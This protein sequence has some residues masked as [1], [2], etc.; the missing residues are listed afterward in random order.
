MKTRIIILSLI[1]FASASN[2]QILNAQILVALEHGNNERAV[3]KIIDGFTLS[4][5]IM[6]GTPV[7]LNYRVGIRMLNL[8]ASTLV[9]ALSTGA[10]DSNDLTQLVTVL[11]GYLQSAGLIDDHQH[12]LEITVSDADSAGAVWNYLMAVEDRSKG[13]H[14]RKYIQRLLQ[15]AIDFM[16]PPPVAH[17]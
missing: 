8:F 11:D 12:P 5:H 9:I 10:F 3:S 14:N 2:I 15:S 13:V 16:S 1:I 6:N 4:R 7:S 17:P